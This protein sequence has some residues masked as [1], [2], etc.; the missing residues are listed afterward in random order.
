MTAHGRKKSAAR[1]EADDNSG[2]LTSLVAAFITLLKGSELDSEVES[3]A[4]PGWR[5]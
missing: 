4:V 3:E 1:S 5:V 2:P